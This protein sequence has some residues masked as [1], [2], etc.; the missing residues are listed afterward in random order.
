[1]GQGFTAA[2][3]RGL[4]VLGPVVETDLALE[5]ALSAWMRFNDVEFDEA[6][7]ALLTARKVL[8]GVGNLDPLTEPIPFSGRSPRLDTLNLAAYLGT[9]VERAAASVHCRPDA[10]VEQAIR[11]LPADAHRSNGSQPR[12]ARQ[13]LGGRAG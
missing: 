10:L 9:L 7:R 8:L 4:L 13:T 5:L 12:R 2:V 1:M 11:Q 3:L 6:R